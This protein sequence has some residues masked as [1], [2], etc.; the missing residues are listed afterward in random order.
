MKKV[1]C[2]VLL[3]SC[4]AL[5]G[6]SS[7]V[8]SETSAPTSNSVFTYASLI[9]DAEVLL[10][11]DITI[12]DTDGGT[13]YIFNIAGSTT[14]DFDSYVEAVK[15][16]GYFTDVSYDLEDSFGAYNGE[17]TYWVQVNFDK[18]TDTLYVICQ[19]AK[20]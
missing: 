3:F 2:F 17:K 18:E 4:L 10:G 19:E 13:A 11:R 7:N 15:S 8:S 5:Y 20:K 9:P 6:C 14:S 12:T 1:L 16:D